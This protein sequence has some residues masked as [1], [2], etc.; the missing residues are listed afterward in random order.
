[1][2]RYLTAPQVARMFRVNIPTVRRYIRSGELPAAKVGRSYVIAGDDIDKFVEERKGVRSAKGASRNP[3]RGSRAARMDRARTR[4]VP[5]PGA[6]DK[7][8]IIR[9]SSKAGSDELVA[10]RCSRCKLVY[11]GTPENFAVDQESEDGPG[12]W[13]RQC[14]RESQ[15][16]PSENEDR[17]YQSA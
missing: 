4:G 9:P 11:A 3:G 5:G 10:K 14:A 17:S 13:C 15:R 16:R 6:R 12:P 2:K 8:W 7:V 1:M